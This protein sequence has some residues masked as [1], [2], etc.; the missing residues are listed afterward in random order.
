MLAMPMKLDPLT[1]GPWQAL[2]VVRPL[3]FIAEPANFA[4][5]VTGAATMLEPAP[6]WHNSHDWDVGMWFEGRPAIEKLTAGMAKESAALPWHCAQLVVVL[7]AYAWMFVSVGITEKSVPVWQ[8]VHVAVVAV[9]M[10]FDGLSMPS[11]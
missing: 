6:T 4:P 8:L 7:G 5:S 11:K 9:G 2:H 10:W 1:F 3:W